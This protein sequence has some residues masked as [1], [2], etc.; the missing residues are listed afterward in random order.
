MLTLFVIE[1]ILI[2]SYNIK[3]NRVYIVHEYPYLPL[4]EYII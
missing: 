2:H 1:P 4:L 3:D